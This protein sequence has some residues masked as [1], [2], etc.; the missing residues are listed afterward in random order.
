MS[1]T[2][3]NKESL[4]EDVAEQVTENTEEVTE[5]TNEQSQE[6]ELTTEEYKQKVSEL[7]S[8]LAEEEDRYLRLRADYDNLRRRTQLDRESQEK[9]R[10]QSLLTDLLPVLDNFERALQVEVTSDD[11]VALYKGIDM[12]Y[13]SFVDAMNKEGLE[14][15][16][17]EGVQ[18]DPTVHQA[19]MQESDSEKE[20]GIILRELQKGYKLKDRVIRPSMVSVNE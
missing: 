14:L 19:V 5:T 12:V 17:A 9:Y 6:I 3:E 16:P 7:E 2:T 11:A 20:S 10:A 18:F 4:K 15:I 13:R 8:K 1:E